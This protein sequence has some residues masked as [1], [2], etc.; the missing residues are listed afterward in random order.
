MRVFGTIP[1][2]LC[3]A[4]GGCQAIQNVT[5]TNGCARVAGRCT[6]PDVAFWA[7]LVGPAVA[8]LGQTLFTFSNL[9]AAR[10][11]P[12]ISAVGANNVHFGLAVRLG[13]YDFVPGEFATIQFVEVAAVP[14]PATLVLTISGLGSMLVGVYRRRREEHGTPA[15]RNLTEH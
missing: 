6:D 5:P 1:A 12:L 8:G 15:F 2:A 4:A 11:L 14:E 9:D 3:G 10:L 13:D 7:D